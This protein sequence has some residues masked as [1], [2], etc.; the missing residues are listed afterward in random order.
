MGRHRRVFGPMRASLEACASKR[1]AIGL[2][3]SLEAYAPKRG[4]IGPIA[5]LRPYARMNHNRMRGRQNGARPMSHARPSE[6]MKTISERGRCKLR[7]ARA[8]TQT[9]IRS[10][11]GS[12]IHINLPE[13]IIL[14]SCS[15]S[16][17]WPK[18][19]RNRERGSSGTHQ[20][21]AMHSPQYVTQLS[22]QEVN[23]DMF[24]RASGQ[25]CWQVGQSTHRISSERGAIGKCNREGRLSTKL[26]VEQRDR[27]RVQLQPKRTCAK[28]ASGVH[29]VHAHE[30][31]QMRV[32]KEA[33]TLAPQQP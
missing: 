2:I 10:N 14:L 29:V 22:A 1:G 7:E 13:F 12:Q 20:R 18:C 33:T 21:F 27:T 26:A 15:Q 4:A 32:H 28:L 9:G 25:G 16:A 23:T 24:H 30:T 3:A 5:S 31:L 8:I 6:A 17:S 11:I 19:W